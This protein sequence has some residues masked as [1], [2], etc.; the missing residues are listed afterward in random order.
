[1]ELSRFGNF[2]DKNHLKYIKLFVL[3]VLIAGISTSIGAQ[4]LEVDGQLKINDGTQGPGKILTS[5]SDGLASWQEPST[6]TTSATYQTVSICCQTWMTKNLDV[7]TYRNGDTI[8]HVTDTTDW[9]NLTTGAYC[10]YG[11]DSA[12]YAATYGKL[13]NWYAVNDPRGLAPEGWRVPTDFEF[14]TAVDCLGGISVAAGLL[15]ELGTTHWS[16][17]NTDGTNLTGFTLLP[18]GYRSG[19][20]GHFVGNGEHQYLHTATEEDAGD[21]W[22]RLGSYNSAT[23]FR[24]AYTKRN[25]FSVRCIRE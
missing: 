12:T 6:S 18:A 3:I 23:L 10:Y 20:G 11:N 1:M 8:P 25:G 13:Y 16:G 4:Q 21:A 24:N 15:K 14:T 22:N 2:E 5:N 17:P 19:T 7:S 9:K